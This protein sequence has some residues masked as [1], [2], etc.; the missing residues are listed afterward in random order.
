MAQAVGWVSAANPSCSPCWVSL[1][2][3]N[4]REMLTIKLAVR[5]KPHKLQAVLVRLPI[6]QHEVWLDVAVAWS[7][8]SPDNG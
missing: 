5:T 6:D 4:L 8:Q 7:L 3:P 2:S 1:C